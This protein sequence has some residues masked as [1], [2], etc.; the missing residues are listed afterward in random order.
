MGSTLIYLFL[1]TT[2]SYQ[3][4]GDMVI[5]PTLTAQE[6]RRPAGQAHPVPGLVDGQIVP[7]SGS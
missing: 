2:T 6:R 5:R 1:A 3:L 7:H 4:G